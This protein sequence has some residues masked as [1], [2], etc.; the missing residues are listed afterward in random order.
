MN[1]MNNLNNLIDKIQTPFNRL[2]MSVFDLMLMTSV[3][4]NTDISNFYL[5]FIVVGYAFLILDTLACLLFYIESKS[6]KD[7]IDT[8]DEY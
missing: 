4:I 7:I 1:N 5:V 6:K 2:L 3:V 8:D